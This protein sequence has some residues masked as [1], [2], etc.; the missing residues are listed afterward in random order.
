MPD[1]RPLTELLALPAGRELDCAIQDAMGRPWELGVDGNPW[2]LEGGLARETYPVPFYS[3]SI[4]AADPLL[5]AMLADGVAVSS[6]AMWN[7]QFEM[8]FYFTETQREP[9]TITVP[10]LAEKPL[11][12]C[13]VWLAWTYG[14]E[15]TT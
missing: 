2:R 13:R 6:M 15:Q 1:K 14:K 5:D 10:T 11:A 8:C 4:A 9:T 7:N 12:I 3:T